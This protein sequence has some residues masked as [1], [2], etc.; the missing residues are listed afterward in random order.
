MIALLTIPEVALRLRMSKSSAQRL[1][2]GEVADAPKLQHVQ[3]GRRKFVREDS[4][5]RFI[6]ALTT[7][8]SH[9]VDSAA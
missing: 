5:D 1:I 8:D 7:I 2:N 6:Q 3:I 4:L 9:K